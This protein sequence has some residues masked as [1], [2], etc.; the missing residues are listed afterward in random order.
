MKPILYKKSI[1]ALIAV[2]M[3]LALF[4]L[5][6]SAAGVMRP[7]FS[8]EAVN[9]SSEGAHSTDSTADENGMVGENTSGAGTGEFGDDT[10]NTM[11]DTSDNASNNDTSKNSAD[12]NVIDRAENAVSDV[13]DG[14]ENAVDDMTGGM[15]VWSI[16]L[17]IAI[18]VIIVVLVL[19]FFTRRR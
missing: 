3:T 8:R 10:S 16:M 6:A 15:S 1:C 9:D 17:I 7:G 13:V 4:A 18:I 11:N 5:S 12:S 2:C 19:V 14:A